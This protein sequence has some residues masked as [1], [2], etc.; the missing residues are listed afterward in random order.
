MSNIQI[1][2]ASF[3]QRKVQKECEQT[4]RDWLEIIA[5]EVEKIRKEKGV[6][7]LKRAEIIER[8]RIAVDFIEE[9]RHL[10][11]EELM[12]YLVIELHYSEDGAYRLTRGKKSVPR[13]S[14][15]FRTGKGLKTYLDK[16]DEEEQKA[17]ERKMLEKELDR[18]KFFF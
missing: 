7:G 18:P 17:Y 15:M 10:S 1:V 13:T 5:E 12:A 3:I 6:S 11:R 8:N 9:N 16:Q 14:V 4:G 2:Q